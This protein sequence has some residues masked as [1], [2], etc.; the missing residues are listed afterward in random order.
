MDNSKFNTQYSKF[1]STVGP[2]VCKLKRPFIFLNFNAIKNIVGMKYYNRHRKNLTTKYY[3]K[4][5][6]QNSTFNIQNSPSCD[7]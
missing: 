4:W 3:K 7:F 2:E 5:I 1:P 6:I